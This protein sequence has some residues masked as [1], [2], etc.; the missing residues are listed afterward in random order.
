[1][2]AESRS[3]CQFSPVSESILPSGS[4]WKPTS[5]V[6]LFLTCMVV[7]FPMG[8]GQCQCSPSEWTG[9]GR[10]APKVCSAAAS[11]GFTWYSPLPAHAMIMSRKM[12]AAAY[13]A[14]LYGDGDLGLPRACPCSIAVMF[15]HL[16]GLPAA[17]FSVSGRAVLRGGRL[18]PGVPRSGRP[19][20]PPPVPPPV[21]RPF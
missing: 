13:A 7:V 16:P 11:P 4:A 3:R 6:R 18:P 19:G 1:M 21:P 2:V 8:L 20:G 15:F 17:L 14:I 10:A 9:S 5:A 12:A